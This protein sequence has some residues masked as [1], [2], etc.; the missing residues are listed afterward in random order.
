MSDPRASLPTPD[1]RNPSSCLDFDAST[2]LQTWTL[3]PANSDS[4]NFAPRLN[5]SCDSLDVID[6]VVGSHCP[7]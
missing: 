6:L 3:L 1:E 7:H 2:V 4:V 5:E